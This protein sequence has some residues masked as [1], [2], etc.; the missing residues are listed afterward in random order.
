MGFGSCKIGPWQ[1]HE[2]DFKANQFAQT[3]KMVVHYSIFYDW[4][5]ELHQRDRKIPRFLKIVQVISIRGSP[6]ISHFVKLWVL[7]ICGPITLTYKVWLRSYQRQS[8]SLERKKLNAISYVQFKGHLTNVSWDLLF[9]SQIA[10]LLLG[11]YFVHNVNFIFS[12]SE[13]EPIFYTFQDLSNG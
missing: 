11:F 1:I 3:K 5:E 2:E 7:Q 10:S 8:C 9:K 6:K 12:N 4:W 13:Y